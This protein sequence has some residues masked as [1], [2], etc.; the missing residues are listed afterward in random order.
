MKGGKLVLVFAFA[1][2]IL[3]ALGAIAWK[4]LAV[5]VFLVMMAMEPHGWGCDEGPYSDWRSANSR[6]DV[7]VGYIRACTGI[8][9]VVDHWVAIQPRGEEKWIKVIEHGDTMYHYPKFYWPNDDT[10]MID[11]GKVGWVRS[12]VHR[13]GSIKITY[14]YSMGK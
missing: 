2:F 1:P 11:L 10:L 9:T 8:G 5:V 6:G 3:I 13:L 7:V 14:V 12:A 4:K